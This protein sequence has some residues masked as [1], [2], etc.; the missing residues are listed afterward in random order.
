MEPFL[1]DLKEKRDE[2]GA[3]VAIEGG[4]TVP[5]QIARVYY[6]YD[7][8]PER[9][10]GFHAHRELEQ[11]LVCVHGSCEIVVD[12]GRFRR[13]FDLARPDCGLYIGPNIWR[14]M[15]RFSQGA[16]LLVMASMHY[17]ESD[18]IR[19]YNDFLAEVRARG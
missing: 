8:S 17:T 16:V 12:D 4:D 14:E 6:L 2:R 3:L 5:F 13:S 7:T 11:V 18:Y 1:I 10:R 19:S 15:L 9:D